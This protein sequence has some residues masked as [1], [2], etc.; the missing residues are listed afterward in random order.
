MNLEFCDEEKK[1]IMDMAPDGPVYGLEL[2]DANNQLR[3]T[4]MGK[5]LVANE[6]TGSQIDILLS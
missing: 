5:L 2:L 3:Q 6:A 4:D 1:E